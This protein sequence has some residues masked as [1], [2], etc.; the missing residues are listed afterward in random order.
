MKCSHA[1]IMAGAL[2]TLLDLKD[3]GPYSRDVKTEGYDTD[4]FM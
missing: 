4:N 1:D 3:R 2:V